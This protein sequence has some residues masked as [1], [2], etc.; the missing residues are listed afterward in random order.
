MSHGIGDSLILVG[1]F[2]IAWIGMWCVMTLLISRISGWSALA[3]HYRTSDVPHDVRSW[4]LWNARL[5]LNTRYSGAITVRPTARGLYLT[6]SM[7]FL[8]HAPLFVP[9]D[10]IQVTSESRLLFP[11]TRFRFLAVP[12]VSLAVRQQVAT[13][14]LQAAGAR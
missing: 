14:I 11:I 10:Q 9:W 3:E 5:R 6:V 7:L 2:A 13:E 12:S 1:V 8:G 4:R